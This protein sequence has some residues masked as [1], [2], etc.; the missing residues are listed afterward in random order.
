MNLR[1]Q[2]IRALQTFEA[3]SRH[4]SVSRAA[5]ELGVTQ[6]AVSHQLR[7]LNEEIAEKLFTRSGR[8]IELTDAGAKLASRLQVAFAQ[9]DDSISDVAGLHREK[10]R[11]AVYSSFAPGWL[12]QRIGSFYEAYPE[13]DLQILMY[14]RHPDLTD[15]V[16]DAF[17]TSFPAEVGFWS[18]RLYPEM[19]VSVRVPAKADGT[20]AP[21]RLI[22][23]ELHIGAFAKDWIEY[24]KVAGLELRTLLDRPWLQTS[25]YIFAL[26]M[27]RHG[28]GIAVVPDF[29]AEEDLQSGRLELF[30][31]A[32]LATHEDYYLCVKDNRRSEAPLAALIQWFRSQIA[33]EAARRSQK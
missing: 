20:P 22:T 30:N 14:D 18:S 11:L 24:C 12:I 13:I 33:Y 1:R 26:E 32:K 2:H 21:T 19:L 17:V 5:D 28:L 9:I 4:L 6:S 8:S 29:L 3:V 25:H 10:L 15:A 27:A 7:R 31:P 16:A 23:S